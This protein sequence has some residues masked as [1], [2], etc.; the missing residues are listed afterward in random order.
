LP[1]MSSRELLSQ[2]ND[3][4]RASVFLQKTSREAAP[5]RSP[6]EFSPACL[7][8]SRSLNRVAFQPPRHHPPA[9]TPP[10]S[11]SLLR[12]NKPAVQ[13]SFCSCLAFPGRAFPGPVAF[14]LRRGGRSRTGGLW[15]VNARLAPTPLLYNRSQQVN[16]LPPRGVLIMFTECAPRYSLGRPSCGCSSAAFT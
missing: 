3:C 12:K 2:Q 14:C 1:S 9:P 11:H 15:R 6:K 7:Q 8:L 4:R 10:A 13:S 16:L 5:A